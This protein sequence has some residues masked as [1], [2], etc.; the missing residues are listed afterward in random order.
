MLIEYESVLYRIRENPI[1][2]LGKRSV[3]EIHSY[4]F[5]YD[6]ARTFWQQP[7]LCRRIPLERFREWI[8]S[9]VHLRRHNM[10][11]LCLLLAEDERQAF[12]LYFELYDS[13]LEECKADLTTCNQEQFPVRTDE[14]E[15]SKTLV[16]FLF[17][18]PI[19]EKTALYFGNH[20]WISGLW[21]MCN[22]F[23]WAEKDMG[24]ENSSDAMNLEL[25]KTWLDERY[26][27]AEGK[28]WDRL[29]D[30]L[31]LHYEKGALKEFYEHFEMFLEGDS[32][33]ATS[34]TV[35]EILKNVQKQMDKEKG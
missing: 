33:D 17:E 10:T 21:T 12:D 32:P 27:I 6:L 20:R 2:H 23:L 28:P 4:F 29:F 9:K 26:P 15:K 24:I 18:A 13:A 8:N 3:S 5:G 22:G 7:E 25:F 34:K 1:E 11:S 35:K 19:R 31:A 16:S 30:F 14:I